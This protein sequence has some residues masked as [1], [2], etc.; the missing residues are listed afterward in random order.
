MYKLNNKIDNKVIENNK[1]I[2]LVNIFES[3]E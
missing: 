2:P 1:Y 3:F